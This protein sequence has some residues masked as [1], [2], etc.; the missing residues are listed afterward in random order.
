MNKVSAAVREG[1]RSKPIVLGK[2]ILRYWDM[3]LL[4]LPAVIFLILFKYLPM[5]GIQIAFL[6]YNI[7][8]GLEGSEWVG[9]K[10]FIRLLNSQEFYNVL[11]NTL[12]ISFLKIGIL[13]PMGILVAVIL[14]EIHWTPFKKTVQ[15]IIY[16]PHFFSWII[17]AGLFTAILSPSSGMVNKLITAL[18][19]D[20][21]SFMTSTSWFRPVLIFSAGW[22]EVGWNAIIFIAAIAG[23]DQEMYEAAIIDGAGR[24]RRIWSIT[25]PS[26]LPTI[27]LMFILR[28]GGLLE[29]G[30]EQI[31]AMYNPV[32]YEVSDVLGTYV[33][34]LGIGKM[35][36][37][38]TTAVGLFNSVVSF[39]LVMTGNALSRR[40]TGSS[41]W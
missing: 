34:R 25:L 3:Y 29:A 35:D 41:I 26:I 39:I 4:L 12:I 38:F 10:N 5:W 1:G 30:N 31:L 28:I 15:T 2:R 23:I 14:N 20:S 24:L 22:K 8:Q 19:G 33:Y 9:F 32:V 40:S 37:S 13:F 6:D 17:V 18:G 21:V 36:Y 16:V 7:F 11:S 27:V